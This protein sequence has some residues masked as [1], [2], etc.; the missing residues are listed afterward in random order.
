VNDLRRAE[1]AMA[2]N[3]TDEGA[4]VI[5]PR[6]KAK[7]I[8]LGQ[9]L[10]QIW[11]DQALSREHRKALL[12]CLIDKV[13]LR[14]NTRGQVLVR[15]VW[16]G[17]ATTEL[18]VAVAVNAVKALPRFA[19]ME[20]R[21]VELARAGLHDEAI[22]R[23][24][25]E[26]GHHSPKCCDKVL[27]STIGGMRRRL[28]IKAVARRTRWPK[29][30]GYLT[31]ANVANRLNVAMNWLRGKIRRGAVSTVREPSGRYLF[32][33]TPTTFEALRQLRDRKIRHI[34][35][36]QHQLENGGYHNG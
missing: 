23:T 26:E 31:V 28:E 36:T 20:A 32:P 15:I 9:T 25:T 18:N 17:G 22:A 10:P 11:A 14:R 5:A 16:R 35:F 12:R 1:E 3:V 30:D 6:L 7:I 4:V 24:L 19:E 34:D 33:D 21:L 8:T 27:P 2:K 13:I 29:V